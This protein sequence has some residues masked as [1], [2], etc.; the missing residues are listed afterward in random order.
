MASGRNL[1]IAMILWRGE[2]QAENGFKDGLKQLGYLADYTI[3]NA[4]Q[5][6]KKLGVS[7][8]ALAPE[9]DE[10]D[11][12]Y[13]F[14]T[15]V[16]RRTQVVVNDRIPQV[17]NVVTDPV[18]AGIVTSMA[19]SGGNISG[20][21]DAISVSSQLKRSLEVMKF[22]RLG[23]FFNPREKNSMITRA[24]IYAV[25]KD[26]GLEVIDLRSPPKQKILQE[27]LHKLI[28]KSIDVDAVYLPQDSFLVSNAKLIGAQ[29]RAAKLKSI[30]SVRNF[31]E[32]GVLV[33]VV[34][35]YYQLGKAVARIIDRHQKGESLQGIPIQKAER[36]YLIINKTTSDLLDMKLS[37]AILKKAAIVE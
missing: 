17:F 24:K 21:S 26:Y 37:E 7:L 3:L 15:T 18:G 11:Y 20:V 19:S 6:I 34:V 22:K 27:N 32:H 10:F 2:T 28:D 30:G 23:I 14:G 29:L 36:P 31:I 1:K 5:D 33:G 13:T 8:S 35:D 16:S 25:A 4:D 9:I 12:I